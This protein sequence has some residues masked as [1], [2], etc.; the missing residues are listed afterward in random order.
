MA[1]SE[2]NGREHSKYS[3]GNCYRRNRRETR[4]DTLDL[5]QEL[6]HK[7]SVYVMKDKYVPK[8]WRYI[9][10][11][12]A[13]DYARMIRDCVSRANDIWLKK[14]SLAE[15]KELQ[16]KALSYCNILQLQL[17][18][19]IAECDGATDESMRGITDTLNALV[20]KIIKWSKSDNEQIR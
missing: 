19:I 13:I 5:A 9:N 6:K 10:G 20:G 8:R 2:R 16:D 17:M 18:D 4:F 3:Y 15:R 14:D 1:Q 11:K 12:P 7:V